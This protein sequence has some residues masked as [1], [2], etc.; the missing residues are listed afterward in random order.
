MARGKTDSGISGTVYHHT[1]PGGS[2]AQPPGA[3]SAGAELVGR[4]L[5]HFR[6]VERIGEGG[7]GVVY[8]AI[9]EKLRRPV[10]LKVLSARY[11]SDDRNK[12]LL[13]REARSAAAVT[14]PNIAAIYDVHEDGGV[15]FI[16]M[17]YVAGQS[18]AAK[19]ADGGA[20]PPAQALD[21]A[22]QIARTLAVAH[23]RGIVH[24]DLKTD[25][26]MLTAHGH[27]KI[28]DF[29]LAKVAHEAEPAA[30]VSR[31]DPTSLALGATVPAVAGVSEEG[32]VMGTPAYM[33]PEQARGEVVDA[34]SD[35]FSFGVVLYE[36]LTGQLPFQGRSGA[37]WEWGGT[38][39][40]AWRLAA[41]LRTRNPAA[42]RDFERIVTRCLDPVPAS[43]FEDGAALA[44]ALEAI[45]M[46]RRAGLRRFWPVAG[47][48]GALVLASTAFLLVRPNA[49]R[50]ATPATSAS[51]AIEEPPREY[52][53]HRLTSFP[54][55]TTLSAPTL[56]GDGAMVAY[57][58]QTAA[59]WLQPT[60]PG[61]RRR[62]W[63]APDL[64]SRGV[65]GTFSE[66]G[67]TLWFAYA[68]GILTLKLD[69]G[70]ATTT[71][72]QGAF[73]V[74]RNGRR[75]A[76]RRDDG[77][78]VADIDGA[79]PRRILED[80]RPAVMDLDGFS[81]D[82]EHFVLVHLETPDAESGA[83][84]IVSSHG[85][86]P[87]TVLE[88]PRLW[89]PGGTHVE[90][91]EPDR[92]VYVLESDPPAHPD[93]ELME[94]RIAPDGTPVGPPRRLWRTPEGHVEWMSAVGSHVIVLRGVAQMDAYVLALDD[95]D[96]SMRDP[97][98]VTWSDSQEVPSGWLP[99]GRL[100]F[101]S[102]VDRITE[103]FAQA[104]DA[105]E[106]T[107]IVAGPVA[108]TS[109]AVAPGGDVLF[110]RVPKDHAA[111]CQLVR[112]TPG[113]AERVLASVPD[114]RVGT[115]EHL[116]CEASIHC[117]RR[118]C[119]V[120]DVT[121]DRLVTS[122]FDLASGSRGA[123]LRDEE[124]PRL[125]DVTSW[126]VEQ[127]ESAL[128]FVDTT[129]AGRVLTILPTRPGSP[130]PA[131][132]ALPPREFPYAVATSATPGRYLAAA[133]DEL[134]AQ[135]TLWEVRSDG[136]RQLWSTHLSTRPVAVSPNGRLLALE[137]QTD[138][139]D[140]WLLDPR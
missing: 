124:R 80:P 111:D 85:G 127:D 6:V 87:K 31:R 120:R 122:E 46:P 105:H 20:L 123:R 125:R 86:E 83:I 93:T 61:E 101:A 40:P 16:A 94:V 132:L 97:R 110:W 19:L 65:F 44:H 47:V 53:E 131:P 107:R 54:A 28:L 27:V 78:Y 26:V 14:H 136:S 117:G 5:L 129:S 9:D 128:V 55:N 50:A 51:A 77:L 21:Y 37:P 104:P 66:D 79:N 135:A 114:A 24:R 45:E 89:G 32:R 49:P 88:S 8:K 2:D 68:T 134:T 103:I 74:S 95:A 90:W 15:A 113:G 109:V 4:R 35:V 25:N 41:P 38:D 10:A 60:G 62:L 96:A 140:I 118:R 73:T 119:F 7:M 75:L 130:V 138:D 91:P 92:L 39:S 108:A 76:M 48:A 102:D 17:E 126:A 100:V 70:D 121:N 72:V 3:G 18:L 56:S 67:R 116:A 84:Q 23:A 52:I 34:R 64:N 59:V 99:D 98:R 69:T 22:L 112:A 81:P 29:G 57:V 133:V 82:A 58:D 43:R 139:T 115:T 13:F 33:S 11:L 42:S 137:A 1:T 12:R 106:P 63:Q 30:A 71:P 36:V